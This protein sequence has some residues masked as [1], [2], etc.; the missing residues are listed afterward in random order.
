MSL[1]NS[2][3]YKPYKFFPA[4]MNF[5]LSNAIKTNFQSNWYSLIQIIIKLVFK[6]VTYLF[7]FKIVVIVIDNKLIYENCWVKLF[8]TLIPCK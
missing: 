1:K 3:L 7:V 5:V 2:F 4:N 6:Q 8:I